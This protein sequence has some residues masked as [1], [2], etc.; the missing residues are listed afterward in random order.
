MTTGIGYRVGAQLLCARRKQQFRPKEFF[1]RLEGREA[2]GE[3]RAARRRRHGAA[4]VV[5]LC[6]RVDDRKSEPD[7]SVS[8]GSGRVGAGETLPDLRER[9]LW[10][11]AATVLDLDHD[12]AFNGAIK[13]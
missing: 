10:D 13:P 7:A 4:A 3:R 9:L 5:R 8:P 11:S 2:E 12:V 1:R 6:N